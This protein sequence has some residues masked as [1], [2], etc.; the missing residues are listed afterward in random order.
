MAQ[1]QDRQFEGL[2][3]KIMEVLLDA[4][5]MAVREMQAGAQASEG[6]PG[7][8][9]QV[10]EA[11]PSLQNMQVGSSEPISTEA[12]EAVSPPA[13]ASTF[14]EMQ[15]YE[16]P[17]WPE[18][19]E[20]ESEERFRQRVV[21]TQKM[22]QWIKAN[23][24]EQPEVEPPEPPDEL[25]PTREQQQAPEERPPAAGT[26]PAA[27]LLTDQPPPPDDQYDVEEEQERVYPTGHEKQPISD[28]QRRSNDA[29]DEMFESLNRFL[30]RLYA[31][32][33]DTKDRVDDMESD[34]MT[35]VGH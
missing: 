23:E 8:I 19:E 2:Q 9:E 22:R 29:M 33:L 34:H 3:K 30:E 12:G 14:P 11:K 35:R 28:Y 16:M 4:M 7:V 15:T 31:T 5:R 24:V 20:G 13:P 32:L 27:P 1:N 18:M 17:D 6:E 26:P 21:Q 25:Q 10:S